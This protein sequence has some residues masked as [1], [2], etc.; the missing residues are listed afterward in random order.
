TRGCVGALC[1]PREGPNVSYRPAELRAVAEKCCRGRHV[2][3][4]E[5]GYD[6]EALGTSL[7]AAI[8]VLDGPVQPTRWPSSGSRSSRGRAATGAARDVNA[9]FWY[10]G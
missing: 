10:I 7:D 8:P 4:T 5:G 9:A 6:L 2:A 1:Y 3:V